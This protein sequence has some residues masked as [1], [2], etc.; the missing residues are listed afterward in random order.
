[1]PPAPVTGEPAHQRLRLAWC[2]TIA[3]ALVVRPWLWPVALRQVGRLAPPGWW[4]HRPFLP[5]PPADYLAFRAVTM[6]GDVERLPAT[7]DVLTYLAWCRSF[8]SAPRWGGR[9]TRIP[10]V[11]GNGHK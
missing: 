11:A 6:Y 5:V 9:P 7:E 2:L 10:A 3:R 4:R 1:M 8:P